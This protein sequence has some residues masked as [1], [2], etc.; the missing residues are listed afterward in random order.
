[1]K[2]CDFGLAKTMYKD[3]NYQKKGNGPVP[4]K[5]MA[6][7]SIRDRVFSTQSDIWSFGIVLWE[8]FTLAETPYPG[9]KAETQYQRL[10]EGYRME[11]PKYATKDMYVF[12]ILLF[13][14]GNFLKADR[15][16][17]I[18]FSRYNTML[19]CWKAKPTLRPTF[20][21]LVTDI[22]ELLEEGVRK[23][24]DF[25]FLRVILR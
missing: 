19:Q 9:M 5:W 22:G 13:L 1:M 10:I 16:I 2:I 17:M 8:F 6:V 15:M 20:S 23:V 4:I 12:I 24:R 14:C 25:S 21:D 18:F 11:Q 7:E 3:D